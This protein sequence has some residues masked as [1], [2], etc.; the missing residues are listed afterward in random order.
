MMNASA[1]LRLWRILKETLRRFNA[2]QGLF[3]ASGL[4]F[5][6]LLYSIPLLFIV[7]SVLGYVLAGS[8]QAV[9]AVRDLL[10]RLMPGANRVIIENLSMIV[11]RRNRIGL[12]GLGLFFV[13]STA[14]FGSARAAL[15]L[16]FGVRRPRGFLKAKGMDLVI[17]LLSSGLFGLTVGII[18]LLTVFRGSI[19]RIPVIGPIVEPGTAWTGEAVGFLFTAV[20]FYILYRLCPAES[21]GGRPLVIASLTGAGLVEVSKWIF[22]WYVSN[23]RTAELWYGT[24]SGVLFLFMWVYY[25]CAAFLLAASLGWA[26]DAEKPR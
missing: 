6:V 2:I 23:T 8:D 13:F 24:L 7:T 26:L 1:P 9:G 20:L 5:E 22:V 12:I 4:A 10:N 11:A 25:A 16:V 14:L 17:T 3:L 15:N 21:P 19:H 18:S